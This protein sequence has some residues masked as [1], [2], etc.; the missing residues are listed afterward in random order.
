MRRFVRAKADGR[1]SARLPAK[2]NLGYNDG[3]SSG[4]TS[5][6]RI[7]EFLR[8]MGA[9]TNEQVEHVLAVQCETPDKKF[10]QIAVELGYIREELITRFLSSHQAG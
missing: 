2:P 4:D 10:G 8:R 5:I 9:L 1:T 3:M 6:E 7:G